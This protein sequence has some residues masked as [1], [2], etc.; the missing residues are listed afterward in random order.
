MMDQKKN[1]WLAALFFQPDKSV[2]E[3]VNLG[4][5][6]DNSN[7]K[8]REYY[9]G[10]PEI[11]E[12]FKN[13]RGEFDDQKFDTYYKDVLDLY[14]KADE[15]NLASNAME[16]FK[17]DP[18]DYFAP[19]GKDVLDVSSRLVKFSNPERRSRGIVN[20]YETSGPTMSIREVAQTNKIFNYDTGKFED[21]TP[22]DWG[23]LTS[24]TRPTLVLAQW[25]EDGTHEVNGRTVSHKA[26]DLKFN[27]EGDPYYETLGNRSLSNKDILHISDT[28]TVDGSVWNKYDFFDSDGLDKSIGGTLA[29]TLFKV[30]PMLIPY[31][32]Q[33]YGAM[34]AA[35][36]LGKLFPVLFRSIEGI[37]KGDLT[38][39]KSAQ[40]ATDIQAWFSRFDGSLSDNGRGSFWN[41]EN[42]GKLVEDSSRQLFQQRVIGQIPK[43]LVGKENVTE[44]TIKWGRALSLTYMAGTSSTDA[45]DAFKQAGASDRVAGLGM[46][47]VMGAMFG[48]M[49]NDYFRDFWFK[50][51]YLDRTGVKNVIKDVAKK[52]TNENINKGIVSPKA[53]AGWIV[54]TRN[55]I[56][57]KLLSLPKESILYSSLNEGVEEVAEEAFSDIVKAMYK[58]LNM[59][60]IVDNDRELDFGINAQDIFARYTS[61]FVGGAIGGAIFS[62][63]EKWDKHIGAVTDEAIQKPDDSLQ[64]II[65]LVRNGRTADLR[66]ELT[67]LKDRGSLGSQN[68][69][70]KDFELVKEPEG[71]KIRYK[72]AKEGESQND[73]IYN[74][75]NNYIDRIDSIIN[76]E[77]LNISD[78]ELQTLSALTGINMTE[79][80][81]KNLQRENLKNQLIETGVYSRIFSDWNN[82]TE[83]ILKTKVALEAKITPAEN[84]PKT[85]KDIDNKIAAAQ[86]DVEFQR[87]KAKLDN[88]REKRDKIVSGEFNDY[89][90][91]Q[92]RFAATPA[93]ATAF[94]DDLGIH[95]FTKT[96]YQKDYD[97]LTADE[98]VI[99]KEEYEKYSKSTE[100]DKVFAAYDLF[101]SLN[102]NIANDLLE[103]SQ[104]TIDL[105]KAYKPGETVQTNRIKTIDDQIKQVKVSI[106][107]AVAKLPEGVDTDS[108]ITNLHV[109]LQILENYKD[110]LVKKH[111]LAITPELSEEG[112]K[113]LSRPDSFVA[114]NEAELNTYANSYI[115]FLNY[116]RT[117]NLYTDVTDTDLVAL[118]KSYFSLNGFQPGTA[119]AEWNN[120]I[121]DYIERTEGDSDG[122]E[123]LTI[124]FANDL[125]TF[126]DIVSKGDIKRIKTAY[127]N[128]LSTEGLNMLSDFLGYET[129]GL[130]SEIL[131][132]ISGKTF[133]DFINEVSDIKSEI[134]T[135]PAYE[136]LEKFAVS[137]NGVSQDI[138][139]LLL[140]EYDN[141]LNSDSLEDYIINN[142]D[143]LTRLKE[144]SRFI[145]ILNSLVIASIDGGYNSQINKFKQKLAKDL[146]ATVDPE[147]AINM[148]TDLKAIKIRIDT[149]VNIAESNNAQKLREQKDIAINMRQKFTNLLLNNENS[150][151]KDK[152]ASLF[153]IDLDTL[154]ANANF[155]SEEINESN[156]KQFEEASIKLETEI[157]KLVN[158]QGLSNAEIVDRITSL[159]S[160]QSLILG[161]PTKLARD[162]T[163]ITDYDQAMYLLSLIAYPSANF[164]NDLKKVITDESFSKAP[165]F[166]QE[167]AIRLIHATSERKDLFNEFVRSLSEKANNVSD[168]FYVQ[169]KSKLSNFIAT[170]G[171]AGT[172]KTQGVAYVLR[173]MMPAYKVITVAPTRKQTDRL[174][175]AI[176]HDGL[177]YTKS[178]LIEQIIGRQISETDINQIFD[179][180]KTT[181]TLTLKDL[182][183]NPATMFAET[184]N[185]IIF[186]DEISQFSKIDLELITRWA[187]KN[188][189]LIVG[190][191]DYKQNS[192]YVIYDSK[193]KD[194]GIEDTY[195]TR[196]PNLTAPLRP[197]NIA[198]YD[199]YTILNSI[200]DQAWDKYYNDPTI[201]DTAINEFTKQILSESG[202]KLKYFE[203]AES[204]GGEKIIKSSDE[205]P[206]IVEKLSKI[207]DDVAI[208]TD[209]PAKYTAINNAKVIGL[210]SVQ[211]D[212]FE[213]AIID[214]NWNST[215]GS[216]YLTLKDLYTLTQRST[217]GT[218]IV[219][220]G[221]SDYLKI[222]SVSDVTSAGN[223]EVSQNQI[224][225]FKDW[226]TN[227]LKDNPEP[228]D[229]EETNPNPTVAEPILPN[230]QENIKP[231]VGTTPE[232]ETVEESPKEPIQQSSVKP[233]TSSTISE[234]Q[235]KQTFDSNTGNQAPV[236]D[237]NPVHSPNV[238]QIVTPTIDPIEE[239]PQTLGITE[240]PLNISKWVE[241]AD[242]YI[243]RLWNY[244]QSTESSLFNILDLKGKL[245]APK[246]IKALNLIGS[247]F[248][249]GYYKNPRE[250]VRLGQALN[251][252]R[253]MGRAFSELEASL[254]T[255]PT[256][257]VIPHDNGKRGLLVAKIQVK[258]K[259]AEIPLM[260]TAPRFGV[261]TGDFVIGSYAQFR[262]DGELTPVDVANFNNSA[263]NT[264]GL[265]STY[266]KLVSLVVRKTDWQD[267]I[268]W[269]GNTFEADSRNYAFMYQNRGKTFMLFSAD[270]LISQKEFEAHLKAQIAEDGTVLNTV[271]SDPRIRLIRINSTASLGDI[272]NTAI[273]NVNLF[274]AQRKAGD[275]N[276]KVKNNLNKERAGQL[277]SLAYASPYKNTMLFRIGALLNTRSGYTNVLRVT[278]EEKVAQ[279]TRG[280]VIEKIISMNNGQYIV[281]NKQYSDLDTLLNSEFG[282]YD[283][284]QMLMQTGYISKV[285][286][287]EYNDP[288]FMIYN[289]FGD[290]AGK[291]EKLQEYISNSPNF[292][293]GIYVFDD[294]IKVVPGS[295]FYFE[296]DTS[297]KSYLTNAADLTGNDFIIDYDKIKVNP[298]K[299][300]QENL[301][302]QK[303]DRINEAFKQFGIDKHITNIDLLESTIND[304]NN[305]I[306][307]K[308]TT[309][310]YTLIQINGTTENPE[311][312]MS[313]VKNDLI[314]MLKNLF[315]KSY[316]ETADSVTIIS[317]NNLKFVPFLVSL[318]DNT[319]S[320]VLESKDG[321][322]SIREF[323]TMNQYIELKDYLNSVKDLYKNS[324]NIMTYL[325]ALMSNSEVTEKIASA[326]YNEIST[327]ESLS[328]LGENV[329]KYLIAKLENN[330]C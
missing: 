288:S 306:L 152:F 138:L 99:I 223:I 14:N 317:K 35:V 238:D 147:T 29:K 6:P 20:L 107:E 42:I 45:Y 244:D 235:A 129:E 46:L 180:E 31:V 83:D 71:Y 8:D 97:Q 209:N 266:G 120:R 252:D 12:A 255:K 249:Y 155:P 237:K 151:I 248:K 276:A 198:K 26:G 289:L 2:Q 243:N 103:V 158:D 87:L 292:K 49:N 206:K 47:S 247:Y 78:E 173:R 156:F 16:S 327:N 17:Y 67:R 115:N 79:N 329:Q 277:I 28:L 175:A 167:Y 207:S 106:D 261:Y 82:L 11:Q 22:N 171:G 250:I 319:K 144:T 92:A 55:Q 228:I 290:F 74:Q 169:S 296:V 52:V 48:L 273:N 21:W 199:N 282:H 183:L 62:F 201:L 303:I 241:T 324:S 139:N 122:I 286:K 208:I 38:N 59:V 220:G 61:S 5:T 196:T 94:V 283:P 153:N 213:F 125:A 278:Y 318:D 118:M 89:Y 159:F 39:S 309:P 217:K 126:Q 7:V 297:N 25:D 101:N 316:G 291:T 302:R 112:S 86:N 172:G 269:V 132:R 214:K 131:P 143:V 229:Y 197:N 322:Y 222:D 127:K 285:G 170:F 130:L 123:S 178:E 157:Y 105:K 135:S 146:L 280:N 192:A 242:F 221:I 36:E 193:R 260:L 256:F 3:L 140:R 1:D 51:T 257:E 215:A 279:S 234:K 161:K 84:E 262:K 185:R 226:R 300:E 274:N 81:A 154:I 13:D 224:K 75:I 137:T 141:Y 272:I 44:N 325:K 160:P 253:T 184:N 168:D 323:N 124:G 142:K 219:D 200:L 91:G 121:V 114:T 43:W 174:S 271:Q 313:E 231:R 299:A 80:M 148:S 70:G 293:Q 37:A 98:K 149:L 204:F 284:N 265:F 218:I 268:K 24:V 166:S 32:G 189:I 246:Y 58:G 190:L 164:Y 119:A 307:G 34:T 56:Q 212:E 304:I 108:E 287:F 113:V 258:G 182:D 225:D 251:R 60:G 294:A 69:S 233:E 66:R 259:T 314:P 315:R 111:E 232:V 90:F 245:A 134:K 110:F 328:Q 295:Q 40:T 10:I 236:T 68:L 179:N 23:G 4:V 181:S 15:A 93:L 321:V 65:Y 116:L 19:L 195:F 281:D 205:I 133:A 275:K 76:E 41:V 177:S 308:V 109:K 301:Q 305:E 239:V 216:E 210:D 57:N 298:R 128:L 100:K 188:N 104:K 267:H 165:I 191:G 136:L 162:T 187:N 310:D 326:Y 9:K 202:V 176:E 150:T 77:G 53:A 320:F 263:L 163:S 264:G 117:N 203:T 33:V 95:N 254:K 194:V 27:N 186:I 54:N 18:M 50:D 30:G 73:I 311:I 240:N 145:D 230:S 85:P 88:L 63:H 312:V 330:E 96:R 227:L 72:S 211:G 64:E 270:P 102:E